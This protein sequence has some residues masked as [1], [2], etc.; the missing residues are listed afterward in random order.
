MQLDA[1]DLVKWF[2]ERPFWIQEAARR[3]FTKENLTPKDL[4]ELAELCQQQGAEPNTVREPVS[5]PA[6]AVPS[7][8]AEVSLHLT[9]ISEV[10]GIE[11]LSPRAPLNFTQE[12]L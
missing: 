7:N 1:T 12:P 9:T 4:Q 10:K 11:E 2:Q 6:F 3:L 5:L 8:A